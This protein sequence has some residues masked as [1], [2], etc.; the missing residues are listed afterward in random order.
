VKT[1][2]RA[3]KIDPEWRPTFILAGVAALLMRGNR[4][5]GG[6]ALFF[7]AMAPVALGPAARTGRHQVVRPL[8]VK[9]DGPSRLEP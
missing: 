2:R 3:P 6:I 7:D 5:R 1:P 4:G 8:T 9:R